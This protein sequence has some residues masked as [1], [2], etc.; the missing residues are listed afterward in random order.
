MRHTK[1]Q[2]ARQVDELVAL[3][4]SMSEIQA[5]AD[6]LASNIKRHGG[7]ES[8]NFVAEVIRMPA[9][10]MRVKAHKQLRTHAKLN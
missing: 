7:A 8:E 3:R 2:L 6:L 1:Q 4:Q 9:K 10:V 5:K